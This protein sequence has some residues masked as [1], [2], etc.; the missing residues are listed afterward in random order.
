[1]S[2]DPPRR[3]PPCPVGVRRMPSVS[4]HHEQQGNILPPLP[5]VAQLQPTHTPRAPVLASSSSDVHLGLVDRA[6]RST[7]RRTNAKHSWFKGTRSNHSLPS[8]SSI[9]NPLCRTSF[10]P[11]TC[12]FKTT[13]PRPATPTYRQ[14]SSPS[15]TT[16]HKHP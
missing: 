13:L 9:R 1:M 5:L 4:G 3:L 2:H 6:P 16:S 8:E 7:P 15:S 14:V 12:G 10:K 11:I